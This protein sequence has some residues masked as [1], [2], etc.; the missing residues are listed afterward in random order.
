MRGQERS[1]GHGMNEA[2][3]PYEASTKKITFFFVGETRTSFIN[4][5]I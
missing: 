5:D 1:W 2:R 4:K 3:T